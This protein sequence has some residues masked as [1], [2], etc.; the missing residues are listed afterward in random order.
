MNVEYY[1][2]TKEDPIIK[3]RAKAKGLSIRSK[4]KVAPHIRSCES[5][6]RKSK[7]FRDLINQET[8]L[9]EIIGSIFVLFFDEKIDKRKFMSIPRD[10]ST[11]FLV[12]FGTC[13]A[14][15]DDK[16]I[17]KAQK[18]IISLSDDINYFVRAFHSIR[19]AQGEIDKLKKS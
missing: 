4:M 13:V 8:A 10:T 12:F 3:L 17:K 1:L 18:I 16:Y 9:S 11:D 7:R 14:A 6:M 15:M 19:L 5:F 2:F